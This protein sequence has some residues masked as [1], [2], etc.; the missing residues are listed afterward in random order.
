MFATAVSNRPIKLVGTV[1]NVFF[2]CFQDV[3]EAVKVTLVVYELRID[4]GIT[5]PPYHCLLLCAPVSHDDTGTEDERSAPL[6][7]LPLLTP[8]NSGNEMKVNLPL[9]ERITSTI[10]IIGRDA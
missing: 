9:S 6:L 4:S 3:A 1:E 10:G 8:K 2:L 7:L 5:S